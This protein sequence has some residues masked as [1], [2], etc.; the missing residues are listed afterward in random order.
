MKKHLASMVGKMAGPMKAK[1]KH[2]GSDIQQVLATSRKPNR[3]RGG[4]Q[5]TGY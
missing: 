3:R 5:G 1:S 4:T 2:Q